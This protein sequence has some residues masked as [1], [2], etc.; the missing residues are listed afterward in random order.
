MA[1][2]VARAEEAVLISKWMEDWVKQLPR[3]G[4]YIHPLSDPVNNQAV[5]MN[6]A[7][8]GQL[9]HSM[10]TADEEI[11]WYR[12]ITPSAWNFSPQDETGMRGPAEESL[13]GAGADPANPVEPGLIIQSF[14]PC[15]SCATHFIGWE[16]QN[17]FSLNIMV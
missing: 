14:D 4:R 10:T 2:L 15:L 6:D 8:R 11:A 5:Q 7:P 17:K 3:D 16:G 13:I 9:L 12:V 1:R